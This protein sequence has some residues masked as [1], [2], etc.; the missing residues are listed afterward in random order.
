MIG[1][2][3]IFR[4]RTRIVWESRD[5]LSLG[6]A[7]RP[8]SGQSSAQFST[9]S[10]K[11]LVR[12]G[13]TRRPQELRRGFAL[14]ALRSRTKSFAD[15]ASAASRRYGSFRR[16]SS[17]TPREM[18]SQVWWWSRSRLWRGRG[19]RGDAREINANAS[20]FHMAAAPRG[21]YVARRFR[22]SSRVT[23]RMMTAPMITC[24]Q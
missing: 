23:A 19:A 3:F 12:G 2:F 1:A 16:V 13:L 14:A 9:H 21:D 5:V 22:N 6:Y 20:G 17:F 18:P 7:S 4:P 8:H 11:E 10:L 15:T 24:C